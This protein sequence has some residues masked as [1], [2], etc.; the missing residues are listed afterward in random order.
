MNKDPKAVLMA[1]DVLRDDILPDLG[2]RMEDKGSG[3]D[4]VTIWKL[5]DPEVLKLEK[6]QRQNAKAEKEKARAEA[7]RRAQEKDEKSKIPPQNIFTGLT[8]LYSAFDNKGIPTHD[9]AKEP[10]SKGQI[11]KLCKEWEK[12][13]DLHEKYLAKAAAAV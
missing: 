13:K 2:V 7:A 6:A 1:A 12:Q 8:E 9:A 3:A 4:L 11:K 10:L 5:D